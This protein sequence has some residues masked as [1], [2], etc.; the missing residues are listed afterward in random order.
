[1]DAPGGGNATTDDEMEEALRLLESHMRGMHKQ[2]E[3]LKRM[4][5]I[6]Q[7][8]TVAMPEQSYKR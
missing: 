8:R 5:K 6:R 1:M 4:M 2:F 3:R 7:T